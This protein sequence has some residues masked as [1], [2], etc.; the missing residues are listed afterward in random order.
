MNMNGWLVILLCVF[1]G[2]RQLGK[3]SGRDNRS[4][5]GLMWSGSKEPSRNITSPC[6]S[7]T[8]I[9]C[10]HDQG[11]QHGDYWSLPPARSVPT[12]KRLGTTSCFHAN[13]V[14][15]CGLVQLHRRLHRRW[16]QTRSLGLLSTHIL[17]S[18]TKF[19]SCVSFKNTGSSPILNL[20][21][22]GLEEQVY[23]L[24]TMGSNK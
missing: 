12:M 13:T 9:G 6:G 21:S 17:S 7:Q 11:L 23:W 18:T 4:R 10:L 3:C 15:T 14:E 20:V 1:S 8:T 5:T 22:L 16:F 19:L 24:E 2:L